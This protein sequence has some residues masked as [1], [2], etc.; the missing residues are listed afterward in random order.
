MGID[1]NKG[2]HVCTGL[3]PQLCGMAGMG[4]LRSSLAPG[5]TLS[6]EPPQVQKN[7][8]CPWDWRVSL[9]LQGPL[10]T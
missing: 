9:S 6:Q 10:K 5:M 2:M 8:G 3:T 4:S 1:D 7:T